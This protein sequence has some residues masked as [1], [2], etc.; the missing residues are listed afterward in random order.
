MSDEGKI[1]V[2]NED[3]FLLSQWLERS[4]FE[5]SARHTPLR[6]LTLTLTHTLTLQLPSQHPKA[7]EKGYLHSM[8]FMVYRKDDK[9]KTSDAVQVL[10]TYTFNVQYP[11]SKDDPISVNNQP[12]TLE[13]TKMQAIAFIRCLVE[14]ASTLDVLPEDRWLTLKLT[15]YEDRTP[16]D[17]EPMF[18][19]PASEND[20]ANFTMD[21][22]ALK[23]RIGK[24]GTSDHRLSLSYAGFDSFLDD[25][26]GPEPVQPHVSSTAALDEEKCAEEDED[27]DEDFR[28]P[29]A[30][31]KVSVSRA[32]KD[33]MSRTKKV[34]ASPPPTSTS[35]STSITSAKDKARQ[36][37]QMTGVANVRQY[38]STTSVS[39]KDTQAI[40]D[41]LVQEGALVKS[42]TR[43]RASYSVAKAPKIK[44]TAKRGRL[45]TPPRKVDPGAMD[46]E[47]EQEQ[48]PP[49]IH[50]DN[51]EGLEEQD[52]LLQ[53]TSQSQTTLET[54]R[55]SLIDNAIHQK[56]RRFT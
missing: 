48:E 45:S 28:T 54:V 47:Q 22:G 27:D 36:Y 14:F 18:F 43:K 29:A 53:P 11:S 9:D 25:C 4:V 32:A 6:I 35:T 15:Y 3:A 12:V 13:N 24:M 55:A 5:V 42:G 21:R 52:E 37:V 1:H 40:F 7:L 49:S 56:K 51:Y 17:Y 31:A 10:E 38:A 34:K 44:T 20:V 2:L 23:I 16:I 19:S 39:V 8:A 33:N 30:A 41:A 46:V 26:M 50:R